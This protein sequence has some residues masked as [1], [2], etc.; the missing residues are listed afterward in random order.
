M[1]AELDALELARRER[2]DRSRGSLAA[3]VA[4]K[5]E[6]AALFTEG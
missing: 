5:K 2:D 3:L 1:P 4:E 6:F